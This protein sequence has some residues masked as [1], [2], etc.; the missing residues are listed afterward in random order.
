MLF[1]QTAKCESGAPDGSIVMQWQKIGVPG[2]RWRP[3][4]NIQ[5]EGIEKGHRNE[6][7]VTF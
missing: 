7:K 4:R 3:S 2:V 5:G 1:Y 6:E